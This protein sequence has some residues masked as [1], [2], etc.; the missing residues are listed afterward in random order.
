MGWSPLRSNC[1]GPRVCAVASGIPESDSIIAAAMIYNM[2]TGGSTL[3]DINLVPRRSG[4]K[5]ATGYRADSALRPRPGDFLARFGERSECGSMLSE[6]RPRW[7][8]TCQQQV[9]RHAAAACD[10]RWLPSTWTR[11]FMK[12][13][14]EKKEGAD[15]A[16]NNCRGLAIAP[17]YVGRWRRPV[18]C[19]Y[20]DLRE[21]RT[22]HFSATAARTYYRE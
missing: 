8:R 14:G 5:A 6:L 2:L 10:V 22:E 4:S 12:C 11:R 13:M 15:F 1:S 20:M 7:G 18:T 9:V 3:S 17:L 21:G 19:N 16:Y